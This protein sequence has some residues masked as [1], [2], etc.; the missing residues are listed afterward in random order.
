MMK[1]LLAHTRRIRVR[2]LSRTARRAIGTCC[3]GWFGVAPDPEIQEHEFWSIERSA[4]LKGGDRDARRHD[5]FQD[6]SHNSDFARD[7]LARLLARVRCGR[8]KS[9]RSGV[10]ARGCPTAHWCDGRLSADSIQCRP[11]RLVVLVCAGV[12]AGAG[13]LSNKPDRSRSAGLTGHSELAT[14]STV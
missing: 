7:V 2:I 3:L 14:C 1:R 9:P 5:D 6:R 13:H 10:H 11:D 12:G 4:V 8:G